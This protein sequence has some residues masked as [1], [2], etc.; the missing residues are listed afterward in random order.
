[1]FLPFKQKADATQLADIDE[2]ICCFYLSNRR[3]MQPITGNNVTQISCFY[4]SNRRQMQL[5]AGF[6][7]DIKSCFYLSNRR[8]MQLNAFMK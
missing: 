1:L 7:E 3:Q 2:N 4:L 6:T 5:S 8:Q